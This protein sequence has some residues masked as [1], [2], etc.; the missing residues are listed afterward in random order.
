MVE[1]QEKGKE[2]QY[3]IENLTKIFWEGLM[4]I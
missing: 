1:S 4:E 2:W 3:G